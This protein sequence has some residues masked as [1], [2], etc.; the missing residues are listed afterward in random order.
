[1]ARFIKLFESA[2]HNH[3][4]PRNLFNKLDAMYHFDWDLAA[5][6]DNSLCFQYYTEQDNALIQD[7]SGKRGFIN[8]PFGDGRYGLH[9]W[10]RKAYEEGSK[11]DTLIAIIMPARTN[12]NYWHNFCMI[13]DTV[14]FIHGKPK[15][16]KEGE[17]KF[18]LPWPLAIVVFSPAML[19]QP[20]KFRTFRL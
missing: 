9:K 14:Y 19:T 17:M 16:G 10:V 2:R 12:T 7:W 4:T 1:M 13:S 20:T 5:S 11:P 3:E 15:F 6:P 8:P 18:G